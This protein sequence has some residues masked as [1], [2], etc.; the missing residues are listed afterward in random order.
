MMIISLYLSF[1]DVSA[2]ESVYLLQELRKKDTGCIHRN[3]VLPNAK[4]GPNT[5]SIPQEMLIKPDQN[6]YLQQFPRVETDRE[7]FTG[8]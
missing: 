3:S 8:A 4:I 2:P 7:V 5:H 1:L 6:Q